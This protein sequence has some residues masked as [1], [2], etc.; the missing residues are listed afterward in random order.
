VSELFGGSGRL[1]D[2]V[3]A[4]ETCFPADLGGD[5][6]TSTLDFESQAEID[7]GAG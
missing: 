1:V 3:Y 7:M 4:V 6:C 2:G 5:H